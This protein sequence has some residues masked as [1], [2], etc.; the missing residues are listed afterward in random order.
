MRMCSRSPTSFLFPVVFFYDAYFNQLDEGKKRVSSAGESSSH[1]R[2]LDN[3]RTEATKTGVRQPKTWGESGTSVGAFLFFTRT[4]LG[5][6]GI[7]YNLVR[8]S[9]RHKPVFNPND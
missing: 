6:R 4:T 1:P 2:G 8:L 9:V 5:Y 3:D 7:S